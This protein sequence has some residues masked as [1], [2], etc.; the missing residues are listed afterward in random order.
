MTSEV[1]IY[2]THQAMIEDLSIADRKL[3]ETIHEIQT[4]YLSDQR[5]WII[6]FSGGKDSTTILSLVYSALLALPKEK[7]SKDIYVVSSDTLVETPVVVDMILLLLLVLLFFERRATP[8]TMS[9]RTSRTLLVVLLATR[10]L[11]PLPPSPP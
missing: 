4:L 9:R 5:P 8:S 11:L 6:G 1:F 7:L 2:S 3:T 10:G